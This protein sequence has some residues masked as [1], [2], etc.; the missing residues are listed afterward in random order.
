MSIS[1]E[2][3]GF[4]VTAYAGDA[5]TLLAFNLPQ[6][7]SKN[8]AGF[9]IQYA[10][11]Q[12]QKFYIF[13]ELQFEDPSKH[14]QDTAFPPTSSINAPIH[15]FRWVHIP[16]SLNQGI[17]P[18]YGQYTYTV[19]PRYFDNNGS[20]Q[21]HDPERSVQVTLNVGPFS[22]GQLDLGFT[23]GF[24]QS[25]AF[26]HHFGLGALFRPPGKDL[27]FDT[28]Q[29]SGKNAAGQ[30]YTFAEEYDWLGFT[31]RTKILAILNEVLNDQ[32][33][34]LDV[35]AYDLNAPEISQIL[36]ALGQQG[37]ARII[38]D[39]APLHHSTK[40]PKPEDQ[41]EQLFRQKAKAP[42]AILRGHF[43]RYA[44]DKVLIVS[45]GNT[46]VKVLSGATNFSIT[47]LYV[48]SNHIVVFNDPEVAAAYAKIFDDSWNH[49]ASKAF[50]KTA[51]ASKVF[52][53]SSTKLPRTE[54]T[55]SPHPPNIAAKNLDDMADRIAQ[56]AQQEKKKSMLFAVMALEPG[57]GPVLPALQKIH[58]DTSIFSYG[59][60]DSPGGIELYTRGKRTGV[61]VT[62]KP[63][64]TLL[65]PPF[66]QVPQIEGLGHQVHHKF[67]VCGFN[68]E[69]P[70]VYCGSSNLA[71]GGEEDN[72]DNLIAI[73]DG[74]VATVFAVE[75]L[76]LVDH[77][78]FLD[79]SAQEAKSKGKA[80]PTASASRQQLAKSA[81]WF[82]STTDK[83]AAP[84]FDPKDLH[85]VDREL[86]GATE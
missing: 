50:N 2:K 19:T 54:I 80:I 6:A 25:E 61:L 69:N 21:R 51:E 83:W 62:G 59:I 40:E 35:F 33:L 58:E 43:G 32:D 34:H 1:K 73:H 39:N 7:D 85:F 75:A 22:K 74:D 14:Y 10:I 70:V 12:N 16:G 13:N 60:S 81:G 64:H 47:G 49:K 66:D 65:P 29:V 71:L 57:S 41:F 42:A 18:F 46:P 31:A 27:L 72:G 76:T 63:G 20:L 53:F 26:V 38:L 52:T 17:K 78:D 23:R 56:E 30:E 28:S 36:L 8:L 82:L 67:V 77:F 84:Y 11:G 44:H 9:T 15:K 5:K 24:T 37:R 55:F 4:T 48:N 68:G 45:K 3:N 79:R 86:F